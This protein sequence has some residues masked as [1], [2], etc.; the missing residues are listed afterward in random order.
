MHYNE[1]IKALSVNWRNLWNKIHELKC[2]VMK[3]IID[4]S[5]YGTVLCINGEACLFVFFF[6]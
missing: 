3:E 4:M 6:L 1:K 5:I 2:F